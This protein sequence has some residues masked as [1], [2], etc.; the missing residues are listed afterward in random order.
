MTEPSGT[1][2]GAPVIRWISPG[3]LAAGVLDPGASGTA[4]EPGAGCVLPVVKPEPG[5]GCVLAGCSLGLLQPSL[6]SQLVEQPVKSALGGTAGHI[7][8][9]IWRRGIHIDPGRQF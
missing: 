5:A 4:L 3:L 9:R 2:I 8:D 7:A 1:V 6:Q